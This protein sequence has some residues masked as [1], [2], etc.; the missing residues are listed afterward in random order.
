MTRTNSI[1]NRSS[2][3]RAWPWVTSLFAAIVCGV[4]VLDWAE[5]QAETPVLVKAKGKTKPPDIT[6]PKSKATPPV[7][8]LTNGK[9]VDAVELAK[10]I[11]QE[12]NK[13]IKSTG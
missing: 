11:D 8:T 2:W 7:A 10:L 13:R 12:I 6:P 1:R 9:P 4:C 5:A 3:T